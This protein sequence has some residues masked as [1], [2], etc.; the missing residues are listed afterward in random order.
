MT[1]LQAGLQEMLAASIELLGADMGNIQLLDEERGV[2][3][4]HAHR[5]FERPFLDFFA[6]V[7][8]TPLIAL[9]FSMASN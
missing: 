7:T 5:G 8:M 9:S 6:E 4:I 3:A 2:L 1:D